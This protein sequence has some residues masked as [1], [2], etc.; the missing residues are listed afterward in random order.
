MNENGRKKV[1]EAEDWNLCALV[2]VAVREKPKARINKAGADSWESREK[3]NNNNK[4]GWWWGSQAKRV[5][6][7]VTDFVDYKKLKYLGNHQIDPLF[8]QCDKQ[9]HIFIA[10][11][12]FLSVAH[13][14]KSNSLS[15]FKKLLST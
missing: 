11:F 7:F 9:V 6:R 13:F 5:F 14:K 12:L 10:K 15:T 2:S 1:V 8:C 4:R 3:N